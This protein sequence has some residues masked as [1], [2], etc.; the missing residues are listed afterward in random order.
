ML[1][2][3]NEIDNTEIKITSLRTAIRFKRVEYLATK[4]AGK[5]K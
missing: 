4:E 1:T 5:F 2:E 3:K